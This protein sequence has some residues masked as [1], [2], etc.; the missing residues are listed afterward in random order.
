MIAILLST[1]NG[2]HFLPEQLESFERQ[3][4]SDWRVIWRDDGSTDDTRDIMARFTAKIGP[5][6]CRETAGSG[7]HLGAAQSFL[8][9][10]PEAADADAV[11]FADQDDVWLPD[12][13]ARARAALK[14][15]GNQAMLYCARQYLV[16]EHLQGHNLSILPGDKPGFPASLT[17]NIVHG[18]TMV[19]N[20]AAA[21]LV[22]RIPGP[23]GTVHDWWS[24]IVITACGGVVL[25]DPKPVVLYRQHRANL[26][27]SPPSTLARAVAALRR[28]PGIFMTMMRR[29]VGQ[30]A[31]HAEFLTEQ[32]RCDVARI[33]EGLRGGVAPRSRALRCPGLKRQTELENMLFRLWFMIG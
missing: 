17:Q 24:Y 12:K 28:G 33:S 11:A 3:T 18:N 21:D 8:S 19:M 5:A 22:A 25:I 6:R 16:D 29:H 1:Y 23:P 26:I 20:R 2:A 9:L 15:A 14:T 31:T 30:L 7:A 27:G 10:L 32:A 13:L 4:D